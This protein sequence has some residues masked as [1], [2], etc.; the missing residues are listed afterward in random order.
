[1]TGDYKLYCIG[2]DGHIE[3]RHDYH[4]REDVDALDRAREICGP[5]EVEVWEGARFI[6]R[7]AGDGTASLHPSVA[8]ETTLVTSR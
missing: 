2:R 5:H 7:I 6:A 1:M 8:N 3:R 4:A